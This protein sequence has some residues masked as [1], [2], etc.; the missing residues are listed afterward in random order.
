MKN[1]FLRSFSD[2]QKFKTP[3][4]N[5]NEQQKYNYDFKILK[6]NI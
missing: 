5:E 4:K 6:R 1:Q 2:S 3:L